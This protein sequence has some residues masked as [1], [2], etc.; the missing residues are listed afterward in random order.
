MHFLRGILVYLLLFM[1]SFHVHAA[2][3]KVQ[4]SVW[5]NEAIIA[6]YTYSYRNFIDRQ[7]EIAQYFTAEGWISYSKAFQDAKLPDTI[8]K[9]AYI[10]SAV[11]T[12]PPTVK[13]LEKGGWQATMPI[14]VIY[15]NLQYQQK[16]T[17]DVTI[18]FATAPA[19]QGIR[20]LAISNLKAV[21]ATMPCQCKREAPYKAIV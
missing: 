11:A 3:D 9:N 7:K 6:T 15:K 16:Q 8:Q 19:G 21:A 18:T 10:V 2:L 20:G 4:L 5:A 14:L 12:L 13:P 17:L 1:T